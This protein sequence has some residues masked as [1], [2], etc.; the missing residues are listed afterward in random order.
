M[1]FNYKLIHHGDKAYIIQRTMHVSHNPIL[2]VWKEHLSSD[3]ILKKGEL[4]Y[5]CEEIINLQEIP[6]TE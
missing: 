4:F 5:F 6:E 2:A 1:K 3:I